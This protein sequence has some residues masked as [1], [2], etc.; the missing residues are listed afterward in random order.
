LDIDDYPVEQF[1]Q[2]E[3]LFAAPIA[4]MSFQFILRSHGVISTDGFT[5]STSTDASRS[6]PIWLPSPPATHQLSAG[7]FVSVGAALS[8]AILSVD[9]LVIQPSLKICFVIWLFNI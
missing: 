1:I 7:E 2:H 4:F 3:L 8:V 6:P 5:D 9:L